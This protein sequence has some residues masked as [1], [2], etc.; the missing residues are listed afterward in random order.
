MKAGVSVVT[1][2]EKDESDALNQTLR[3]SGARG[4]FFSPQTVIEQDREG[5][6]VTRETYLKKLM[7]E[8]HKMYPGDDLDLKNYPHLKQIIQ[9]GHES[10]R[11]VIKFKDAMVYA[12][13]R[14]SAQELPVNSSSD[15]AYLT[16]RGGREASS[17]TNGEIASKSQAIWS[18]YL[19]ST[20][21]TTPIFLSLNLE[22]PFA[23]ATFLGCNSH[24]QKVYVPATFSMNKVL[25]GIES[26]HS[27]VVVI[28]HELYDL[29]VPASRSQE[30][31]RKAATVKKAIVAGKSKSKS[32]LFQGSKVEVD[33]YTF[34]G[35]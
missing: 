25:D 16:Y 34:S 19:S 31:G 23:V 14:L 26:Q 27:S 17:F 9:L 21:H 6:N 30:L 20:E 32:Q 15:N 18:D 13:P 8:L 2:E 5:N 11:G 3:D 1:F 29:E 7:P 10:I 28:D 4:L 24:F 22:T 12:N 33:P 35:L